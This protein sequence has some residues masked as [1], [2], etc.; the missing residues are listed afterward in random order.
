V[1][2]NSRGYINMNES[3]EKNKSRIVTVPFD[4]ENYKSI[5][6]MSNSS[7]FNG[8]K[9]LIV[10]TIVENFINCNQ[11]INLPNGEVCNAQELMKMGDRIFNF[12]EIRGKA[13]MNLR[14][15]FLQNFN[16][17]NN[18][19][20]KVSCYNFISALIEYLHRNRE[21]VYL[22]SVGTAKN[23]SIYNWEGH[24]VLYIEVGKLYGDN[25]KLGVSAIMQYKME[26]WIYD[27]EI[28]DHM[29]DCLG[30]SI[31]DKQ[32]VNAYLTVE[33][34]QKLATYFSNL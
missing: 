33:D 34:F 20:L 12:N 27:L 6:M 16:S 9:S 18:Q 3:E 26:R 1:D 25:D 14:R 31:I 24:H 32:N 8:N 5:V 13:R 7:Y 17:I 4:E 28:W 11:S 30:S 2:K 21:G 19:D 22:P 15:D 23:I 29:Y 10:K